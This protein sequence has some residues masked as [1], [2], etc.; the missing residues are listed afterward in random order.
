MT[1]AVPTAD[2]A[3]LR[4]VTLGSAC[5]LSTSS[6][7]AS[8]IILRPGKPLALLI[9]LAAS[10]GKTASREHLLN[11]LW[12]DAE[13][14]RGLRTLRQTV[15]QLRQ[16]LGENAIE[17]T[18]RDLKLSLPLRFDRDEF[19]AA[20]AAGDHATAAALYTGQFLVDFGVPGGADFE[21]WSDRER[22]RLQA[23]YLR[24]A[25]S[26][27]RSQLDQGQN[28]AA[29]SEARRLR[30]FDPDRESSWRLL[31]ESLASSGDRAST[32]AEAE[33][34]ERIL[35]AE[36][37][38]PESLTQAAIRRAKKATTV[39]E[40]DDSASR[41]V[42]ELTGRDRE[43]SRLT[44][45]WN[46]AKAG[47]FRHVHVTA[48][49]GLGKTRLLRD[50]FTRLRASGARAIWI[51]AFSG[52][53]R[54][55]YA[56]AS[57]I[58]G[59]VG[60]LSGASGISTAAAS[61]L[62]A[63]NPKLSSSFAASADRSEGEEAL[64][65]RVHAITELFEA[66]ADEAP[67]AVFIDD[68]HWSDPVSRQLLK[69][70]FSR[71]G[72]CRIL[73]VTCARTVPDG[74]LHLTGTESL[75][76][77][78]LDLRQVGELVCS[79]GTLPEPRTAD[80][81]IAA[82]HEHTGGSPLLIL[83]NLHLAI[84]RGLISR[85]DGTWEFRDPAAL[86]DGISKGDVLKQR[87]RKLEDRL[88]RIL[89]ILAVAEEPLSAATVSS[90]L[91]GDRAA[92][93]ADLATLEHQAL[94]SASG[95][96]WQ[97]SHDSIAETLV[98]M[99]PHQERA[100]VRG[101]LGAAFA[102]DRSA[103]LD[104]LRLAIRHLGAGGRRDHVEETFSRAVALARSSGDRRSHL[105]LAAAMLGEASPSDAAGRLVSSL[106][107][108]R[109]IGLTS[110]GRLAAASAVLAA[111]VFIPLQLLPARAT[112]L[113][114]TGQ[115]LAGNV[116][117][118][119]PPVVEL[120]DKAGRRVAGA[121]DTVRV[122]AIDQLP[123]I[124]GTLEV[125]AVDGRATFNDLSV[126]GEGPVQ[127]RFSARGL[128]GIVS[129]PI[130]VADGKPTLRFI[131]GSIN[132]QNLT[133]QMRR[134]VVRRGELIAGNVLLEYS[135]YWGSASV[136]LGA[137]AL[138]GDREKNFLDL[139]PLFT[140]A[141]NQPRRASIRF[142]APETPGIYHIVFAFDAEGSVEDFMSGT[143]WR[144]PD[145][146]WNDGNDIADWTP[147]QLAQANSQGWAQSTFVQINNATGQ[148]FRDPHPV[149]ATV[150]DVVVR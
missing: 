68:T 75:T 108:F 139:A 56:L 122:E 51:S 150:I 95:D 19:L 105:Q 50:V 9:Y 103:D 33:E 41:L 63:L 64:R 88:F 148:P 7:G 114:I 17:S 98:R 86:I 131:S 93:E 23:A 39:V 145:P 83:E 123:G 137:A 71:I 79:F 111:G 81:F 146:I 52:D 76:L 58:A 142:T 141:E 45:A 128:R 29:V 32:I 25:E 127:L 89:V 140:P 8:T 10:P 69:S 107:F 119:P 143:N 97:C 1:E 27:I 66:V 87:L 61:T 91:G 80:R 28:D 49:P 67:I 42:A 14:E 118:V 96:L 121:T 57:D 16:T 117:I 135:S 43:F 4:L 60:L 2:H 11:L 94:A 72:D 149:P 30:D 132:G 120:Q 37:R 15:F 116:V 22:D 84:D 26:L 136:I 85:H 106:P 5:L 13:P 124:A 40:T 138:W 55:A 82:L 38:Q 44:S 112:Q 78:A 62:V 73:L 31:L 110:P 3:D 113:A 129:R 101:T 77:E 54:L 144:L 12:A 21:H 90:V 92:V 133:P 65:R 18:G 24:S 102:A 48:P 70:S 130:N 74:D 35:A 104:K 53:R 134:V 115:P 36:D 109:R 34:L 126:T 100:A 46:A 59:K 99:V 125:A 6:A 47:H 147:A 20:V